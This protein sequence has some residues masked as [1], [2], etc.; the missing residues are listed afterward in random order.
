MEERAEK[1]RF[2]FGLLISWLCLAI[3]IVL[4]VLYGWR[5]I[6]TLILLIFLLL[7]LHAIYGQ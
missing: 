7:V 2:D 6:L 5:V 4:I 3:I 1:R